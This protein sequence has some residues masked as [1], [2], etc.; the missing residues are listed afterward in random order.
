MPNEIRVV[1]PPEYSASTTYTLGS[2]SAAEP[3]PEYDRFAD[4][5]MTMAKKMHGRTA[6]GVPITDEFVSKLAQEA[7]SGYDVQEAG[8]AQPPQRG[9]SDAGLDQ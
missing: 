9:V 6:G 4:G 7:E 3:S 1:T 5:R 2:E 8:P